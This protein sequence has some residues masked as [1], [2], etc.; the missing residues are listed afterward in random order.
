MPT[1]WVNNEIPELDKTI[2][3]LIHQK[4]LKDTTINLFLD[5]CLDSDFSGSGWSKKGEL[6]FPGPFYTGETDTCGTGIIESPK[7]VILD[8][9]CMEYVMIQPRNKTELLQL[10]NAGAAEV[11]ESYYCDGNKYWTVQLVK[12]WWSNKNEILQHLKNDELIKVNCNQEKRYIY[13][14][15]K[16]AEM[17]LRKYCFFLDNGFYPINEKL[18]EL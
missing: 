6:N 17:D 5:F 12:N 1:S 10:W 4:E 2:V 9:N 16:L 13:Y 18:P 11:F 15:E 7:N 8:E 14:L 3:K